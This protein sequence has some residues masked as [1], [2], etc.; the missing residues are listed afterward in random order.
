[1]TDDE[2]DMERLLN[3]PLY[4]AQVEVRILRHDMTEEETEAQADRL[5]EKIEAALNRTDYDGI[6]VVLSYGHWEDFL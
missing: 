1:M 5:K 3:Q 6:E 4:Q 2:R